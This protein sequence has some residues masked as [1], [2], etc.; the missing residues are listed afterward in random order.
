M[1]YFRIVLAGI[2]SLLLVSG[3]RA[4]TAP[5]HFDDLSANDAATIDRALNIMAGINK[6]LGASDVLNLPI[7]QLQ[8]KIQAQVADQSKPKTEAPEPAK[9]DGKL[10]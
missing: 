5:F 7:I 2:L 4:Q 6:S 8:Q 10:P 3:A 1:P 9:P